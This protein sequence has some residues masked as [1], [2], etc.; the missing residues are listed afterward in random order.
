MGR[1]W[2]LV[3]RD[4]ER[5]ALRAGIDA[6]A[7]QVV[8]GPAGVGKSR[9]VTEVLADLAASG[10]R[11]ARVAGGASVVSMQFA[12]FA[13]LLDARPGPPTVS[14]VVAA[15]AAGGPPVPAG[16]AATDRRPVL[17]VDDAH[18]LDDGSAALLYQLG[19]DGRVRLA[20]TIRSGE[21]LPTATTS[22]VRDLDGARTVLG[23]LTP[24]AA[25]ELLAAV[26]GGPLD[27]A[28]RHR[29][30][31][32]AGGNPLVLRELTEGALASGLLT[33]RAGL[34][35]FTR[36]LVADPL[37]PEVVSARLGPL[38]P[39]E[40]DLLELLALAGSLD[41]DDLAAL[42]AHGPVEALE[43]QG[44][45]AVSVDGARTLLS[46][47][48][49]IQAEVLRAQLPA[50]GR[51]RHCRRL[52]ELREARAGDDPDGEVQATLWRFEAGDHLDAD[53][54]L[55]AADRLRQLGD[56]TAA[57]RLALAS[58][59]ARPTPAAA[60]LASWALG[61]SGQQDAATA[62]VAD[63]LHLADGDPMAR[64]ALSLRLAE[65]HVWAHADPAAA[66]AVL[67]T[68]ERELAGDP[69]ADLMV[70]QRCVFDVLDGRVADV[71]R[72]ARPLVD[73]AEAGVRTTA[74]LALE[75]AL[76]LGGRGDDGAA[77]A[78]AAFADSL[79]NPVPFIG[80]PGVHVI[81]RTVCAIS[82]G[83]LT[84]ADD[85]A[86]LLYDLALAVP[87]AQPRA[88]ASMTRG[89][90][91][92]E[93]GRFDDAIADLTE[94]ELIWDDLALHGMAHWS[95]S[96]AAVAAASRG[97]LA[98][99][100][101]AIERMD[102]HPVAGFRLYAVGTALARAWTATLAE[103]MAT[104]SGAAGAG[105]ASLASPAAA[106][107]ALAESLVVAAEDGRF[108]EVAIGAV[109]LVRL[110]APGPGLAAMASV[111]PLDEAVE[112]RRHVVE[113][114]ATGDGAALEQAAAALAAR[115]WLPLA[116]DWAALA[117]A[118]HRRAGDAA[119]AERCLAAAR[120]HAGACQGLAT[121]L[122]RD[123]VARS[124]LSR[125]EREVA[126]LA[127][128]GWSNRRIAAHFVLSERTVENHLYRA[129]AK[130]GIA[131]RQELADIL[132]A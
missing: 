110:G 17:Q 91:R 31:E 10:V 88:W 55:R 71:E 44:L 23:P 54:L 14:S 7:L 131:T 4:A 9:L 73:H 49:P 15:L 24:E 106:R 86:E 28:A 1:A 39:D 104:G 50:T 113:Q 41:L 40:R 62:A 52:A 130:L 95:A 21:L 6:G 11:T 56:P 99:A 114:A 115:G 45:V 22:L 42:A 51:M 27:G 70:A 118:A 109:D 2:P 119:A 129:F 72:R 74:A 36:D 117:A 59:R 46:C 35:R 83:R 92:A 12:P 100:T 132:H 116:A 87:G 48:H 38:E 93:R 120:T 75:L 37:L 53:R 30:V 94:A 3:G 61:V 77:V 103:A 78:D 112:L 58:C 65:Q 125:R 85:L 20:L 26:L 60:L 111:P 5:A 90:V 43:R 33:C 108:S 123:L 127:A 107:A 80:D 121:P 76:A 82:A 97:D 25:G 32:V 105:T 122:V 29:L 16:G 47:T 66:A 101:A 57:A 64:A 124:P 126:D 81:A 19:L 89:Q 13:A 98:G 102:R 63:H 79:A 84:E 96:R 67:D 68:A 8:L 128:G 18:Q 69:W 34:W